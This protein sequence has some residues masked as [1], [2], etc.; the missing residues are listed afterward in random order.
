MAR[1]QAAAPA[2]GSQARGRLRARQKE[3]TPESD[4]F[5]DLL[6]ESGAISQASAEEN[7]KVVKK[8][9]VAGRLVVS[10]TGPPPQ[11]P[12]E[13]EPSREKYYEELLGGT[14]SASQTVY[15]DDESGDDSDNVDWEDVTLGEQGSSK[16]VQPSTRAKG[17]LSL[18]LEDA[19]PKGVNGP[20]QKRRVITSTER[21]LR[22][23][24][25]KMHLI[26][27]LHHVHLRNHWCND[28]EVQVDRSRLSVETVEC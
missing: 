26:L 25:H 9:R 1:K 28:I 22:L 3:P 14:P 7:G 15:Q 18:V 21:K 6:A 23:E 13:E 24:I 5:Q 19:E 17:D 27:L 2:R 16:A 20:V 12:V 11:E 10:G 4:V 8:R